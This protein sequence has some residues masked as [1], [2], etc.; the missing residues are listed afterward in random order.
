MKMTNRWITSLIILPLMALMLL[1]CESTY[2]IQSD[3]AYTPPPGIP[4]SPDPAFAFSQ[5]TMDAGQRQLFEL[6]RR[7]TEVS[8][9]MSQAANAAALA[10]QEYHRRQQMELDY[11]LTLISQNMAVAAVTQEFLNQQTKIAGD[12][13]TAAQNRAAWIVQSANYMIA[14]QTA[15]AQAILN[16]QA[17]QTAQAAAALTT[18]PLTATPFAKTEA[19]LLLQQYDRERRTFEDRIVAPLIPMLATLITLLI[20]AG[21][22]LWVRRF[23]PLYWP[24]LPHILRADIIP[25]PLYMIDGELVNHDHQNTLPQLPATDLPGLPGVKQIHVEIVEATK[26]PFS[27]WVTEVEHQLNAEGRQSL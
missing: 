20:I 5:A 1:G 26:P 15:Q 8:L 3:Y 24:R 11:Q 21:I 7:A 19:A 16:S 23:R 27:D 10:T 2:T 14:T 4:G 12:A 9:S 18:Y 6:S 17:Q 22:I 13:T 25:P